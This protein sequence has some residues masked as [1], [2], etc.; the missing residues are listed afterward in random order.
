MVRAIILIS[1]AQLKN[2]NEKISNIVVSTNHTITLVHVFQEK[3]KH[4]KEL[5]SFKVNGEYNIQNM[6]EVILIN[7]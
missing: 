5:N 7:Y 4:P 2:Q 3:K 6:K 1:N